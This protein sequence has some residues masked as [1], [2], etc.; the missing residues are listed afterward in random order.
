MAGVFKEAFLTESP[1]HP[2]DTS[3]TDPI[4]FHGHMACGHQRR[5]MGRDQ[6]C[7]AM[8]VMAQPATPHQIPD[9]KHFSG[10]AID[11][12]GGKATE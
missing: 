2:H 9:Q 1:L 7:P 8:S 3:D 11:N 12:D 6:Q 5:I 4:K 10:G